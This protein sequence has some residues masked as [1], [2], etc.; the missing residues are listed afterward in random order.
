VDNN[1][2]EVAVNHSRQQIRQRRDETECP[3]K[4]GRMPNRKMAASF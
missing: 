4:A 2:P 3:V 1:Q